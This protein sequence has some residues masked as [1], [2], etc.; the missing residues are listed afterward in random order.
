MV[1][2]MD[3]EIIVPQHGRPFVGKAMIGKFLD[4]FETLECGIDLLTQKNY[5]AP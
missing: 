4:W 1:R 3:I 2:E 5:T